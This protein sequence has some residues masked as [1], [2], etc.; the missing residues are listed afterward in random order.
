MELRRK[1]EEPIY[2]DKV[3]NVIRLL[4]EGITREKI[5][6]QFGYSTYRSLDTYLNR[7]HFHW[8]S[9]SKNYAPNNN[10]LDSISLEDSIA[11]NSKVAQVIALFSKEVGD[12]KVIAKRLRFT[13]HREMASYMLGKGYQWSIENKNYTK[14]LGLIKESSN[15]TETGL[16]TDNILKKSNDNF[17]E[18]VSNAKNTGIEQIDLQQFVPLLVMLQKN[19]DKLVDMLIPQPDGGTIPRYALPGV[20][21]TKSVHMVNT[22]AIM[23]RDFSKEK[24]VSQR[25]ICEAALIEFFKRY[26]YEREVEQLLNNK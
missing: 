12:S 21:A 24:N 15:E 13:D 10:R 2:N 22:L 18:F 4:T 16:Q 23:V 3:N 6:E 1:E 26:G 5:A 17:I 11:A 8:D 20:L 19:K 7:K 25:D 14:I 9:H